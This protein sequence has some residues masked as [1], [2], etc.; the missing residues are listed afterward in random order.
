MNKD[1]NR[2][3]KVEI[4]TGEFYYDY[5]DYSDNKTDSRFQRLAVWLS[6]QID[7]QSDRL[8]SLRVYGH[9]RVD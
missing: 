4:I 5:T 3:V 9:R 2:D 1:T 8:T 6:N 7:D